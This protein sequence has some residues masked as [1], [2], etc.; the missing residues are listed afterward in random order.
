MANIYAFY[1]AVKLSLLNYGSD[2]CDI[3]KGTLIFEVMS[4]VEDCFCSFSFSYISGYACVVLHNSKWKVWKISSL[5]YLSAQIIFRLHDCILHSQKAKIK[6]EI[7]IRSELN[8]IDF[9][10][11]N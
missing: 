2:K 8:Q 9:Y 10:L 1:C 5:F 3:F 7:L 11:P 4:H 6:H